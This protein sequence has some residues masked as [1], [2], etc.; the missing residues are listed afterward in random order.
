MLSL[1]LIRENPAILEDSLR[2]RNMDTS[3]TAELVALDKKWRAAKGESDRQ[4]SEKNALSLKIS[5]AKKSGH[6]ITPILSRT[7]ELGEEI[8]NLDSQAEI[9]ESQMN[10][11]LLTVPNIPD[12]S[13][14]LGR[15]EDDNQVVR[16]WGEPKKDGGN[17]KPHYE[18][19][20][21]RLI[22]FERGAKLAGHRFVVLKGLAARLERS[23]INFMLNT[24]TM[25][26]YT[27]MLPPFMVNGKTMT[28][29]GQL[30]KFAEELYKCEGD[31]LYMIPTA[32]VPLTN[33]YSGEII[34]ETQLPFKFCAY[35]ACFRREA[36]SYQK[37]IKG[38]IRQHQ[39]DKVELV[40]LTKPEDSYDELEKLV[41]DA[42][43]ILRALELPYRVV[44]LCTG[45]LG[46]SASKT[47]DIEV[48]LPSQDRY[49]EIS[50]CSNC[51]DF[52]AR[53]ANLRFRRAGKMEFVHTLNGSGL[54]VGR[55]MVAIME[56]YQDET[57]FIVPKVL[58]D[59]MGC[60]R[61]DF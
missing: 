12:K 25:N 28:G 43:S 50:S 21:K 2:R 52:Q 56:N 1:K 39:F 58:R 6:D 24:H 22:D 19:A 3:P 44:E 7:K 45:D 4:K 17:V 15:G 49:R 10:N 60:D 35:T 9:L 59:F 33:L 29:T 30:P 61:V 40:K 38:I 42:E 47:Y 31:D 55:T 20:D 37:D 48:W 27:E 51:T 34:E 5:E 32:E 18:V 53:R 23:I 26:G 13:V 16:L 11:I 14:P 54:A 57:G 36:G 8:R 41:R 46:F